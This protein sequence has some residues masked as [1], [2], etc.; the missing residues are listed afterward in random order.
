MLPLPSTTMLPLLLLLLPSTT[1]ALAPPA[2][3][4]ASSREA[5]KL[6]SPVAALCAEN[7]LGATD[8][9]EKAILQTAL[10]RDLRQRVSGGKPTGCGLW[11]VEDDDANVV[12]SVAIEVCKLNPAALDARRLPGQN[13][14]DA[15]VQQRPLLSSLAV[16]KAFRRRGLAQKLCREAELA[17][18]EWGY[19]EVLLK[20]EADNGKARK[21]YRKLGYRVVAVDKK[22]ER[23]EAGPG[24]VRYVPTVQVAM[25]KDLNKP[26][27]DTV[28]SNAALLAATAYVAATCQSEL[29]EAA[30]LAGGG[31]V[32]AAMRVLL[33]L[34]PDQLQTVLPSGVL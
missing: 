25:R 14:L 27:I 30:S 28:L 32:G 9:T 31:D 34:L 8:R 6:C 5:A 17:C 15:D 21:L 16:S 24:G 33:A 11:V 26:P 13:P 18:K 22:A 3:R 29:V 12:G 4:R 10:D 19:D 1:S 20:V 23:P 2:P 7:I